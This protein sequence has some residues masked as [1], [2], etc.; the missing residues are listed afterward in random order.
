[1]AGVKRTSLPLPR[2][3]YHRSKDEGIV[4]VIHYPDRFCGESPCGG[5][6]W[7]GGSCNRAT[8]P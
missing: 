8:R 7:G 4:V 1:M 5:K 2:Y 3:L 6:E